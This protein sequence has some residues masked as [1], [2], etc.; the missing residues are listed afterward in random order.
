MNGYTELPAETSDLREIGTTSILVHRVGESWG[1]SI[2]MASRCVH[3]AYSP[4]WTRDDA[5]REA[6]AR[7]KDLIR[8]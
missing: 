1:Y 8:V 4:D 7:H 3:G 2:W 6:E 5:T